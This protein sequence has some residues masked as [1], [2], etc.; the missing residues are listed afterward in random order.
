MLHKVVNEA[1]II[2]LGLDARDPAGCRSRLVGEEVRGSSIFD[3]IIVTWTWCAARERPGMLAQTPPP[4][5]SDALH[6]RISVQTWHLAR[7]PWHC[8]TSSRRTDRARRRASPSA[9]LASP[10]SV[11]AAWLTHSNGPRCVVVF[12]WAE[13]FF[14]FPF[15]MTRASR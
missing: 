10:T 14:F 13:F 1:D 4:H 12:S 7:R 9:S 6:V 2:F 15:L 8:S 3:R 11:K 5:N